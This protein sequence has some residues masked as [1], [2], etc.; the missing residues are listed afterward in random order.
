MRGRLLT[1][2]GRTGA[3][4]ALVLLAAPFV[5]S[6]QS[7]PEWQRELAAQL[8]K[9]HGCQVNFLTNIQVKVVN[10][11]Q[12]VFARAHCMDK[13]DFD[14]SRTDPAKPFKIEQCVTNAC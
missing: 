1:P 11:D 8:M 3:A 2:A 5:A 6:A 4:L 14:A 12:T 10:G 9:E 13:R 7:A